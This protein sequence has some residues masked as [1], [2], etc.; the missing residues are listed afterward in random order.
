M[1]S[2][3]HS[4]DQF[5][6][7]EKFEEV[8]TFAQNF[9][10]GQIQGGGNPPFSL[11]I[12][13]V[14][15]T[16]EAEDILLILRD[17]GLITEQNRNDSAKSLELGSLLVPQISEYSAIVLAHK[18]RR[19]DCDIEV[20]LSDEVHPSKSGDTNPRGLMSKAGLAQNKKEHFKKDEF[21]ITDSEILVSSLSTLEG[22]VVQKYLGVQ[23]SFIIVDKVEL[24]R[25]M[26]VQNVSRA[27]SEL[28]QYETEDS[29]SNEKAFQDYQ[30]SFDLLFT[31]LCDQ[32]KEK[33]KRKKANAILGLQYQLNCLTDELSS[34]EKNRFQ[35]LCTATLA[36][37]KNN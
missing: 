26:F 16:E 1:L 19:F 31:E 18:L 20:G 14:K 29:I 24:E 33:A 17:F 25:L 37:V 4:L 8:K 6:H 28:H 9:S 2:P 21:I 3:T 30:N 35:L 10:Y 12:R 23:T 5:A 32:L 34:D 7:Q 36:V 15:F 27:K 22:Y 11:I 13:N